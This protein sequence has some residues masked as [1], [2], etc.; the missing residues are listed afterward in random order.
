MAFR[1]S[2]LTFCFVSGTKRQPLIALNSCF[3]VKNTEHTVV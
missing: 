1:N 2:L 3:Y